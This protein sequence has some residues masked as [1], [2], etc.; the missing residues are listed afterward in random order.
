MMERK[1]TDSGERSSWAKRQA[2]KALNVLKGCFGCAEQPRYVDDKVEQSSANAEISLRH[3]RQTL[4]GSHGSDGKSSLKALFS[5][6]ND[7]EGSDDQAQVSSD[8]SGIGLHRDDASYQ[9]SAVPKDLKPYLEQ[10]VRILTEA[11]QYANQIHDSKK[12]IEEALTSTPELL[13]DRVKQLE[14]HY[15]TTA[16]ESLKKIQKMFDE[17]SVYEKALENLKETSDRFKILG[18]VSNQWKQVHNDKE[19]ID[20]VLPYALAFFSS[21]KEEINKSYSYHY[22]SA[23]KAYSKVLDQLDPESLGQLKKARQRFRQMGK[24]MYEEI[25]GKIQEIHTTEI[26]TFAPR[27][28]ERSNLERN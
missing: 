23:N 3:E 15:S 18:D 6:G 16:K 28:E 13:N 11:N 7:L 21:K 9:S 20:K 12:K 17:A 5:K 2:K 26:P 4:A 8:K 22:E 25:K 10:R 24:S 19:Q 27:G 1:R 14:S